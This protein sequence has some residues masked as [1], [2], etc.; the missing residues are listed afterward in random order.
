MVAFG[1]FW[2]VMGTLGMMDL[3]KTRMHSIRMSTVR[4]SGRLRGSRGVQ[5]NVCVK[6]GVHLPRWTEFLTQACENITVPQL[7]LRT[8][9]NTASVVRTIV[10]DG[11][12]QTLLAVK[13]FFKTLYTLRQWGC[14]NFR[15]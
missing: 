6:G 14:K 10:G 12:T 1:V 13:F 4:C 9:M 15:C 3:L 11:D 8:V 2:E 5:G 7:L